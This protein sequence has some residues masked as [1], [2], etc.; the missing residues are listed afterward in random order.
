MIYDEI[1]R[2]QLKNSDFDEDLTIGGYFEK[3][4]SELWAEGEGFSGKRPFG[5]SGWEHDL[6][7]PLVR[8]GVIRGD[9]DEDGNLED[10]DIKQ[11]DV[12][13]FKLIKCCFVRYSLT[14]PTISNRVKL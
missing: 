7:T 9:I 4:L 14:F 12:L 2:I 13:V 10:F 6:Y 5:N 8:E 3:L 11:A 1:L